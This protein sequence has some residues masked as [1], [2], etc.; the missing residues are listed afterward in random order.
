[1]VIKRWARFEIDSEPDWNLL[2]KI[3]VGG[4]K[5]IG[6]LVEVSVKDGREGDHG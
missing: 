4:N 3:G 5:D 6:R 2:V 1:M